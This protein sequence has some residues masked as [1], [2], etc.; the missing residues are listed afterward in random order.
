MHVYEHVFDAA[1]VTSG[2]RV[3]DIGCGPGLAAQVAS[4]RGALVAGLDAAEASIRIA[5]ERTPDGDFRVGDMQHLPWPDR[6]FD[7]VTGFNAFQ[8]AD[9]TQQTLAEAK[10]VLTADGQLG[11][12]VWAERKRCDI[13]VVADAIGRFLAP[14]PPPRQDPFGAERLAPLLEH[15]GFEI[16][17]GG[18]LD[19]IMEFPDIESAV[20]AMLSAGSFLA[21]AHQVGQARAESV[22]A[23]SL[24][25]F[26]TSTG[27]Y[28]LSNSFMYVIG[29]VIP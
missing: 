14:A 12:L 21:A 24:A 13:Y 23:E 29:R 28:R 3:L 17:A 22:V 7:V 18:A 10:R 1:G 6:S 27:A 11:V 8:F 4:E 20:S 26:R 2:T 25:P 19:A 15:A 9:D 16:Q 5:R